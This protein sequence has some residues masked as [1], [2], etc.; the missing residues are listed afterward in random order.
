MKSFIKTCIGKGELDAYFGL[1]F[2]GLSKVLIAVG[3]LSGLLGI[4]K[5]FVFNRILPAIGISVF[6]GNFWYFFEAYKLSKKEN[7]TNVTAQPFGIGAGQLFGFLYLI[8]A[9]VYWQTGD[10]ELA[11]Q[12]GLAACFIGG[13]IEIVGAFVAPTL[14]KFLPQSA[15][16]GNLAASAFIFLTIPC[17]IIVYQNPLIALVPMLVYF[18]FYFGKLNINIK[19]PIGLIVILIGTI[20]S[21][22]IGHNNFFNVVEET[23]NVSLYLPKIAITDLISGLKNIKPYLPVIIPMQLG[24][25]ITTLQSLEVAA[26]EG[27]RYPVKLSM[28]ADGATT[29]IASVFGSPFPT[30]VYYGHTTWKKVGAK[31]MYSLLVGITYVVLIFS[32]LIGI[33]LAIIP[34]EVTVILLI[35][36]GVDVSANIVKQSDDEYSIVF[37]IALIPV[38]IQYLEN[39]ISGILSSFSIELTKDSLVILGNSSIYYEGIKLIANGALLTSLLLAGTLAYIIKRDFFLSAVYALVLAITTFTGLTH[40]NEL[41]LFPKE[42]FSIGI[43][44]LIFSVFLYVI[45][46]RMKK[47]EIERRYYETKK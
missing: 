31:S 33:I 16:L 37:F 15:L 32:G 5:E 28:I 10:Y 21:W 25:F 7:R 45:Y 19:V 17:F 23:E 12:V 3:V 1:L 4:P 14:K 38:L 9:P 40:G 47:L 2:D 41:M 8:M 44:Y 43:I 20:I 30:T 24:N 6:I 22:S 34:Y 13:I 36:V 42:S 46:L 35:V 27:D 29:I 39:I 11:F 18:V 26:K